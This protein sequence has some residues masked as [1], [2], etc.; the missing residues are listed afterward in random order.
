MYSNDK[1]QVGK[2][3]ISKRTC[4]LKN[5]FDWRAYPEEQ[6]DRWYDYIDEEFKRREEGFWFTTMENQLDTRYTLYVLT[7]E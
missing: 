7:M 3:R 2:V 1:E 5:I 4:R 6:K